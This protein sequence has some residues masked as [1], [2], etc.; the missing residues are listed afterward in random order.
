MCIRKQC[1]VFITLLTISI[2]SAWADENSRAMKE[3]KQHVH[4]WNKFVKDLLN[5]HEK[6]I[7]MHTIKETSKLG[8]YM[9]NPDF[10]KEVEYRDAKTGRLLSRVQWERENPDRI[11]VIEVFFYDKKGRVTRDYS[12]SFLPGFRNAPNQTLINL[13]GYNKKLHAFRSFDASANMIYEGCE[14][15]FKNKRV[16]ISLDDSDKAMEESSPDS[17]LK[18]PEYKACFSGIA[19]EAGLFLHPR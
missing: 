18:K 17:I 9:H 14:G 6:R 7:S 13:H 1:L 4:M 2:G 19:E 11:H 8:G 5:I 12:A 16:D 10:Y 15:T 3:D